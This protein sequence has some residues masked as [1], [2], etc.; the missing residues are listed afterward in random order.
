MQIYYL[1]IVTK[2]RRYGVCRVRRRERDWSSATLTP[3]L[4]T[5]VQ[6]LC[7]E[8]A[9]SGCVRPCASQRSRWFVPTGSWTI[10]NLQ[11][12]Q[13]QIPAPRS[14]FRR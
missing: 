14:P 10:S 4:A 6:R 9:W 5:H 13:R 12:L 7:R 2:E 1:E 11:L 8:E 3:H